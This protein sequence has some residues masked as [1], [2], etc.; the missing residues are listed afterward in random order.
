VEYARRT[1][2]ADPSHAGAANILN[3][4]KAKAKEVFL[5]AYALKDSNPEEAIPKFRDVLAMTPADDE[6]HEKAQKWL[7]QLSR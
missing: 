5:Y 4:L 7:D 3:E 2:Q 6:T 1:L